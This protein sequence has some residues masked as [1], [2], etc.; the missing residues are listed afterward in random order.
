MVE[1]DQLLCVV[2]VIES[3]RNGGG[4]RGGIVIHD[5]HVGC[6]SIVDNANPAEAILGVTPPLEDDFAV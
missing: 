3:V 1:S 6:P 4:L 5:L 2:T